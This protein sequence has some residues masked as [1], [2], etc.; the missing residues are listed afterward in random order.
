VESWWVAD[1]PPPPSGKTSLYARNRAGAP[2]IDVMRPSGRDFPLQPHFGVNR[3]ANWSPSITTTITTEGLPITNVGTVSHPT[4]AAT[5]V[6]ASMR[7]WRLTSAAVVDSVAEQRSAGW[8]CW[9]GNAAGLGGWT[10]VTRLSLTTLQA[11]G[12]SFFGLYG[13]IAALAVKGFSHSVSIGAAPNPA[14]RAR[15]A[16]R[17]GRSWRRML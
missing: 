5:N 4:L 15:L 6:A 9:R 10:F 2:W 14:S 11:T 17:C 12:M 3:I 7:R 13:S 16:T 1:P 8:A